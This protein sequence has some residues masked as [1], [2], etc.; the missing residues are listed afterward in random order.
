MSQRVILILEG[1]ESVGKT[2]VARCLQELIPNHAYVK[3]S[4]TNGLIGADRLVTLNNTFQATNALWA[5]MPTNHAVV[6]RFTMSERVYG[7][8]Y[9]PSLAADAYR[10]FDYTELVAAHHGAYQFLLVAD[11]RAI[12]DRLH[13]KRIESP[14]ENHGST[15]RLLDIQK[16]YMDVHEH[17]TAFPEERKTLIDTSHKTPKEVAC[18]ILG[19]VGLQDYVN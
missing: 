14:N 18:F 12:Q 16:R 5:A 2:S 8:Q 13:H 10:V 6:D 9:N 19:F 3:L 11:K 17:H 7:P 4:G 1:T 15:E